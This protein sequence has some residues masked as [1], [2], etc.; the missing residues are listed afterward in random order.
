[1]KIAAT[2]ALKKIVREAI[3][4]GTISKKACEQLIALFEQGAD[5][6]TTTGLLKR[7]LRHGVIMDLLNLR[8][9]DSS[10]HA[11]AVI[12]GLRAGYKGGKF[13]AFGFC[14]LGM[15]SR[16]DWACRDK[17]VVRALI[18]SGENPEIFTNKPSEKFTVIKHVPHKFK[19]ALKSMESFRQSRQDKLEL[20]SSSDIAKPMGATRSLPRL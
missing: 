13:D 2:K 19:D 12:S 15:A 3:E 16:L 20:E 7:A 6:N 11:D 18:E 9:E 1:M 5:P 4:K 10:S 8:S 14:A 17:E